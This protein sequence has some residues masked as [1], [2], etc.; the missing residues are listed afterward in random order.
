MRHRMASGQ[1][2]SR[3]TTVELDHKDGAKY[4]WKCQC[5][6]GK[7]K[8]IRS[9][10]LVNGKSKSCGCLRSNLRRVTDTDH[11]IKMF[12]DRVEKTPA[13]WVWKGSKL[14]SGYGTLNVDGKTIYAHRFSY[15]L[16]RGKIPG[17]LQIDHL[18]R[19]TRCVNPDHLEAVTPSENVWRGVISRLRNH[20]QRGHPMTRDNV[21]VNP[22]SGRRNCRVCRR[23]VRRETYAKRKK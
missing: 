1:K 15:E 21:Y 2:Y 7:I 6:C 11:Y 16:V 8:I 17:K 9:G 12:W 10:D 13:C 14:P 18:C 4:F 20:C 3:W 5:E 22:N 23:Q 19:I